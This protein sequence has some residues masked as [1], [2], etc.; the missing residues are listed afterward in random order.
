M[1]DL[2]EQP[3]EVFT[4]FSIFNPALVVGSQ[5]QIFE[6]ERGCNQSNLSS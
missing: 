5:P 3:R 1:K 2:T 6:V 4:A